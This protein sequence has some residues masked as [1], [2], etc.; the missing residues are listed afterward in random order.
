LSQCAA[1]AILL[2]VHDRVSEFRRSGAVV[3]C[4]MFGI[5]F[6]LAPMGLTYTIGVLLPALTDEFGWSRGEVL[7]VSLV[8]LVGLVPMSYAV[9]WITDRYGIRRVVL[10]SQLGLGAAFA[11]LGLLTDRLSVFYALYFVMAVLAAGTLP[12]TFTKAIT[13]WFVERRGLALG[14][15]L[16]G[17]GLAGF[18][19][20]I[21]TGWWVEHHGWR[22]AYF[23]L[24]ALPIGVALPIAWLAL[25][26]PPEQSVTVDAS[27][28]A[29]AHGL[30]LVEALRGR[31]FWMMA[32]AFFGISAAVSATITNLVPLLRDDG[33]TP[34][35]AVELAS[36]IGLSVIVGRVAV[37]LLV[38]RFWAPAVGAAF[39]LPA[40]FGLYLLAGGGLSEPE[41]AACIV[42]VGLA[43]GAEIDLNA[44]LVSR[45]FGL[46]AYGRVYGLQYLLLAIGA[47]AGTPL[48]GWSSDRLGSYDA[49]LYAGAL[50]LVLGTLLILLLGRY[51]V[52]TKLRSA[53]A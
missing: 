6:G 41:A 7:N 30:E 46:R 3:L 4:A 17:T 27:V 14:I 35:R 16:S 18:F 45:Y 24:A 13:G 44:Y 34:A 43:V 48:F 33:A 37:G 39:L 49:A 21:Y 31:R 12:I 28:T 22:A 1:A 29:P 51:S 42:L 32:V 20:P 9:G 8:M 11:L 40:A 25:R 36:L 47:A 19:V 26:E 53:D 38:D 5:A 10:L 52:R 15:A 50:A 2:T 23:A